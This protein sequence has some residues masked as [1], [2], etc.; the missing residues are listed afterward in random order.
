VYVARTVQR[1]T[2]ELVR[3]GLMNAMIALFERSPSA[4]YDLALLRGRTHGT[5][6]EDVSAFARGL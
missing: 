6:Y 5:W 4:P 1:F 3:R 2:P